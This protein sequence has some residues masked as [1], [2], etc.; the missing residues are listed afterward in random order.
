[1]HY[2][3][4]LGGPAQLAGLPAV[5]T[6]FAAA[7]PVVYQPS[8]VTLRQ[9]N[10]PA[11]TEV[12]IMEPRADAAA[13][14]AAGFTSGK[15]VA[16]GSLVSVFGKFTGAGTGQAQ[17][18][19]LPRKIADT[20]VFVDGNAVPLFYASPGQI[21]FQVPSAT[22]VGQSLVE[23]KVGGQTVTRT[24]ITVL[25]NAPGLFAA[26]NPDGTVN[27]SANAARRGD[28]LILYGT[29]QGA[30]TPAVPDG[31]AASTPLASSVVTPLVF[32][33]GKQMPVAFSG[34]APGFAGLWQIN[35]TLPADAP[36]GTDMEL[37]VVSGSVSNKLL[38]SVKP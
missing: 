19:P 17:S 16:P 11:N 3:T 4:A 22:A 8:T 13:V 24:S 37:T 6:A 18:Y 34:L 31:A 29:G 28:A 27:S 26:G 1:M 14:N 9:S 30:V 15:P 38:V 12:W 21:N 32:L 10:L 20:E 23:V 5:A 7:A 2:K 36:T 35:V 25:A 33:G